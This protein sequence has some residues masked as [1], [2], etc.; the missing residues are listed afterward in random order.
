MGALLSLIILSQ[1]RIMHFTDLFYDTRVGVV[2]FHFDRVGNS[3]ATGYHV[4]V[5]DEPNSCFDFSMRQRQGAW[6]ITKTK[7]LPVWIVDFESLLSDS[8][9]N[10]LARTAP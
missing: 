8:I 3:L 5:C 9:Y 2:E 7:Q 4:A 1:I 10:H 6:H